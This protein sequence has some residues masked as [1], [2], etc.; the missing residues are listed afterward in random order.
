MQDQPLRRV[1]V[2]PDFKQIETFLKVAE[3]RSFAD[4]ARQLGVSQPAV[5]QAIARLED[6]YGADLFERRRGAPVALTVIGRAILPKAKLLLFMVDTQMRRA[7]ETAQSMRGHLTVGFH[8]GLASGPLSAAIA[9]FRET[10]PDVDLRLLEVSPGDLHR[11]LNERAID[12]MFV[13]LLPALEGG[14]NVQERLWDERLAI[15][16][17][18]DHPLAAKDSLSWADVSSLSIMLR[19]QQGDLSAY[20]AIATRMGD[21]PFD[22]ILHDVSRGSLIEMVRLGLGATI[23]LSCAAVPRDRIVYRHIEDENASAAV[24]ALW[25]REDRN[26]LRHSLLSHVRKHAANGTTAAGQI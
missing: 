10:R 25:P 26:P 12:I 6:L 7:V 3:T 15:A 11:H 18:D 2:R 1:A 14:P 20:R 4:A 24:E 21:Q 5:S 17:R 13:A 9:E 16:L 19:A 22:C 23:M 8:P